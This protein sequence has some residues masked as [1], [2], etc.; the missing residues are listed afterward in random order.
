MAGCRGCGLLPGLAAALPPHSLL[1]ACSL[2]VLFLL[3]KQVAMELTQLDTISCITG[4][5]APVRLGGGA[6]PMRLAI[7]QKS[8][9]LLTI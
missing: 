3:P 1:I 7:G 5:E 8:A 4:D 9:L 2:N 6:L